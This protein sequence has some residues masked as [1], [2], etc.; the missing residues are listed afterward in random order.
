MNQITDLSD[1]NDETKP[2]KIEPKALAQVVS[3]LAAGRELTPAQHDTL[4][5]MLSVAAQR[6][7][8]MVAQIATQETQEYFYS[9]PI[10]HPDQL[11]KYDDYTRRQV[12]DMAAEAQ[13][14]THE[15]QRMG[16]RGAILKDR[17]GQILGFGIAV[18]GLAAA[19]F[20]SQTSPIAASI[21][22]TLDLLGMVT[23][24]VAPRILES[25]NQKKVEAQA[26]KP[27]PKSPRRR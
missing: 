25:R 4:A 26:A 20:M 19:T 2:I 23:V 18:A 6:E 12:V 5:K 8:K 9:G 21:I 16:M 22:G 3:D 1:P 14:H 11:N 17:F 15:M 27:K 24:F 7:P 13:R 10:P